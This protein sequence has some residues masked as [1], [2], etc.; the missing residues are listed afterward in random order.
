MY[1]ITKNPRIP[2][3]EQMAVQ[4]GVALILEI[5]QTGRV[6][7]PNAISTTANRTINIQNF[8]FAALKFRY[9]MEVMMPAMLNAGIDPSPAIQTYFFMLS[10]GPSQSRNEAQ[11]KNIKK[12]KAST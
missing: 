1:T 4:D 10:I 3:P 7:K 6:S 8:L 5:P 11:L 2:I 12:T 9:P